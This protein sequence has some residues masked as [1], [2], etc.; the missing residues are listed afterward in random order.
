[1]N[2]TPTTPRVPV[3]R[4]KRLERGV[5]RFAHEGI[6]IQHERI[7]TQNNTIRYLNNNLHNLYFI[8]SLTQ[9]L[10]IIC[11]KYLKTK[12]F[13]DENECVMRAS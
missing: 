11:S 1:M 6:P 2:D 13:D 7:P 9:N 12:T 4:A 3:K 8:K 10:A 5:I